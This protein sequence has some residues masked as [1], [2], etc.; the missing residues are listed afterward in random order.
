MIYSVGQGSNQTNYRK[1]LPRSENS[2]KQKLLLFEYL[3]GFMN[4]RLLSDI[5]VQ[6]QLSLRPLSQATSSSLVV[7]TSIVKPRLT[8]HLA[9]VSDRSRKR[10]RPLLWITNGLFLLFLSSRKR[11]LGQSTRYLFICRAVNSTSVNGPLMGTYADLFYDSQYKTIQYFYCKTN[12]N[13]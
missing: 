10:P 13:H 2:T 5:A 3:K 7:R 12:S 6:S 11:P 1:I 4:E 9:L 8:C